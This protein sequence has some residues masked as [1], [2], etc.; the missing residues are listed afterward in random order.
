MHINIPSKLNEFYAFFSFE[1][2]RFLTTRGRR[3]RMV[4]GFT[5][6]FAIGAYY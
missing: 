1:T 2:S 3:G 4:A 5:T 6:T